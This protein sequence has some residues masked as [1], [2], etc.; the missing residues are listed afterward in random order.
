MDNSLP[1]INLNGLVIS[2]SCLP[3]TPTPSTTPY[4]YCYVS[5]NTESFGTFQCPNDDLLYQDVYGKLLLYAAI[6]GEIVSSH[7]QLNFIV[8]NGIDYQTVSI[9]DGQE[10]IEFVYPKIN[11]FYTETGCITENLPAWSVYTPPVT[12]CPLTTQT[13][14]PTNTQTPTPTQ[15]QTGT[16]TQTPTQTQTQTQTQTN[17][18]TPTNTQTQTQTPT[19]TMTPTPSETPTCLETGDGFN[20]GVYDILLETGGTMMMVGTFTS[21]SGVSANRVS[22]LYRNGNRDLSFTG[23]GFDNSVSRIAKFT[24]GDYVMVGDFT[25]YNGVNTR[26]IVKSSNNGAWKTPFILGGASFGGPNDF[27]YSLYTI[28]TDTYVY[29]SQ[30]SYNEGGTTYLQPGMVR[31]SNS[32]SPDTSFPM[33]SSTYAAGFNTRFSAP[34]MEVKD[35]VVQPNGSIIA[36]GSFTKYSSVSDNANGICRIF[37]NGI[38]DVSFSA[39]TG[40]TFFDSFSLLPNNV[41]KT[42]DLLS[43]G[44]VVV[45]GSFTQFNGVNC[46]GVIKLT[47]FGQLD[48]SFSFPSTNGFGGG[49]PE[50]ILVLTNGQ[51]IVVGSFTSY[52]GYSANRIIKLNANGS[53]DTTF[54]P[55][56]G[57]DATA[58]VVKQDELGFLYIGG[59]FTKYNSFLANRLVKIS[60]SGTIRDC[61]LAPGITATP[62]VTSTSTPTNTRTPTQTQTQTPSVTPT[63]TLTASVTPTKTQTPTPTRIPFSFRKKVG[64][65]NTISSVACST[66][67]ND[68]TVY[69]LTSD[70]TGTVYTDATLT[71]PFVGGNLF[72][73]VK[74]DG[75]GTLRY[76]RIDNSCLI[77]TAGNC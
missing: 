69:K 10:Y 27:Y 19:Q 35:T 53:I 18:Q 34:T 15:T 48:T 31:I 67:S 23:T 40:F 26:N 21:Y 42:L 2:G 46:T 28:G 49:L 70:N 51:I 6:D 30:F 33:S 13:P 44:S 68:V 4:Q 45:A 17:T 9:P 11:F 74:L 1:L 57:F 8:S 54:N 60:T 61:D 29:G 59:D 65:G 7:P 76:W 43:D 55:G 64:A 73:A 66:W 52:S 20:G 62:T 32:G 72:H 63:N 50:D 14:T 22:R 25:N 71:T 38:Y 77:T 75:I 3:V 36:V 37:S 12:R 39:G 41:P 5:A 56:I 16:P 58:R 47:Q 24:N